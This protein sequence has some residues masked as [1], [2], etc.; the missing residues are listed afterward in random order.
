ME[1][2][3][4]NKRIVLLIMPLFIV[5]ALAGIFYLLGGGSGGSDALVAVPK[6]FNRTLPD[7]SFKKE[8]P[9]DKLDFYKQAEQ[10][11]A[12]AGLYRAV[13]PGIG[14]RFSEADQKAQTDAI[15]AKLTMLNKVISEPDP[16]RNVSPSGFRSDQDRLGFGAARGDDRAMKNDVDRLEALMK[17]MQ[18]NKG[19]DPEV[20]QLNGMLDKII[21]IQNPE[22]V[23]Q[24][25]RTQAPAADSRFRAVPAV[26][27]DK[28]RV[29]Q[30]ATVKLCL[31]DSMRV[32]GILIPKGQ[33][34]FGLCKVANHRLLIEVKNIRMGTAIIPVNLSVYS[35][36]GMPGVDAP[37]AE[38]MQAAGSGASD[39]LQS[40]QFLAMDQSIGTQAAGAGI[41]A[42]K[43]L[44]TKRVRK[45]RIRLDAG[46][47][48]LLRNHTPQSLKR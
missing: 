15:A 38:L 13:S 45:V 2:Q 46:Q 12:E 40:M 44:L 41:D 29:R 9:R 27:V 32:S 33:E 39:A 20:S 37:E 34:L 24:Q 4:V 1:R 22:L 18:Q 25:V 48:V 23:A 11:S 36:D 43:S 26:I 19:E 10:D 6:G 7:A 35:L 31:Q 30:D 42:A 47:K 3:K 8:Q 16:V 17:T 28:Q 14:S 21:S 5:G